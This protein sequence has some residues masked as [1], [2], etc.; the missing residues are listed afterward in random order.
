MDGEEVDGGSVPCVKVSRS[1]PPPP[2]S[3]PQ[4]Q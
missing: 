3:I 2:A 1:P 4:E